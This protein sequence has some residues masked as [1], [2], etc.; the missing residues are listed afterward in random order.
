MT[1]S[2]TSFLLS[3]AGEWWLR[4][5]VFLFI[6][7][8]AS[9]LSTFI[10]RRRRFF[11]SFTHRCVVDRVCF[12]FLWFFGFSFVRLF[13]TFFFFL[14]QTRG[15][16][17]S[18]VGWLRCVCVCVWSEEPKMAKNIFFCRLESIYS[19]VRKRE[20][21]KTT[22]MKK[23]QCATQ[24]Y[25]S[26]ETEETVSLP[27]FLIYLFFYF[28]FGRVGKLL[29]LI[30]SDGPVEASVGGWKKKRKWRQWPP[31]LSSTVRKPIKFRD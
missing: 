11:F 10:C 1:T 12:Y 31:P 18:A 13:P 14:V 28:F 27:N 24:R 5:L 9:P 30:G 21:K 6:F 19:L 2:R 26:V 3:L 29:T 25:V 17:F 16:H 7:F 4:S 22:K 23:K 8:F 15:S 20:R